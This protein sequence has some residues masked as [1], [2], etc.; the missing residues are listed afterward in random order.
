[1][2]ILT[3]VGRIE[4]AKAVK[5]QSIYLAWG[6]GEPQWDTTPVTEQST[7]TQLTQV[8]GYRKARRVLYCEPDVNGEIQVPEGG[9][10]ASSQATPHIYC[11]FNYDF[12][13]ALDKT[14]REL[15][16]MVGTQPSSGEP[17]GKFYHAPSDIVDPGVLMLVEHRPAMYRDQG[18]RETFE[19]VLSF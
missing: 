18:V 7:S 11:E 5:A 9:F 8:L 19:F 14:I 16:L 6:A 4:L 2:A 13:D 10:T 3:R 12:T 1:M 15:G 17:A